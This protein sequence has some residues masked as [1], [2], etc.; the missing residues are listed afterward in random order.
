MVP[1]DTGAPS[2]V[3]SPPREGEGRERERYV[4]LINAQYGAKDLAESILRRARKGKPGEAAVT[5]QDLYPLDQVHTGG[6]EA[7]RELGGMAG[8]AS[9]QRILDVGS[10]L[11]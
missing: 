9:G 2:A 10:G 3:P 11:G 6:V 5:A 7:T 1:R 4:E 8:V